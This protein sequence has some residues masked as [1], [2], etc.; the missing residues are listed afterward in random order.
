MWWH[1]WSSHPSST[2]IC[3]CGDSSLFTWFLEWPAYAIRHGLNP[4]YSTAMGYPHGINLLANTSMLAVGVPLAPI[5]WLFGPTATLNVALLL[6]PVLSGMA[7]YVLLRRWVSWQPAAFAGG[8]L[9]GFSPMIVTSLDYSHLNFSI[10]PIPPLVVI[11]LDELLIRQRRR[12]I[13]PGVVLGLL[14]VVQFF[15]STE[16]LVI[17]VICSVWG[18][19]LVVAYAAWRNPDAL[20]RH[21]RP[22]LVGVGAAVVTGVVLLAYPTWF[23][24][25][26]PAHL[27]GKIWPL[28]LGSYVSDPKDY[29]LPARAIPLGWQYGFNGV[30]LSG[31]Y[32]GLGVA[33]VIVVGLAV[34]W[35]DLRLWLFALVGVLSVALS[36]GAGNPLFSFLPLLENVLPNRFDAM[37]YLCAAVIVGLVV[38]HTYRAVNGWYAASQ[39]DDRSGAEPGERAPRWT[40]TLGA[41]TMAV[42]ALVPPALYLAQNYPVPVQSIAVPSWFRT[43][44][45]HLGHTP[46]LLI[47]PDDLI[48]Q[49]AMTW[50]AVNGMRYSMVDEGG[51]GG[52]QSRAGN[53]QAG[54]S[55]IGTVSNPSFATAS[56][57]LGITPDK[58]SAVR[59]ALRAWRVTTVVIPD[60]RELPLLETVPSVTTAA[61]LIT[62]ATGRRPTYQHG[63]WV[64]SGVNRVAPAVVTTT[65][66]FSA[67]TAANRRGRAAVDAA[68][69]C[70]SSTKPF[71]RIVP[72]LNGTH[73]LNDR[74]LMTTA[75]DTGPLTQVDFVISGGAIP[76]ALTIPAQQFKDGSVAGWLA[77]TEGLDLPT[78]TY[79]L[80]SI[81]TN[82]QGVVG[83]S[84][85]VAMQIDARAR[86][87]LRPTTSVLGP[88]RN[89]QVS[90]W[91]YLAASASA[92]LGIRSA[93]FRI[94]GHGRTAVVKAFAYPYG[95]LG[96]WNTKSVPNGTYTV[97]SVVV[98][99]TGL[100]TTSA[101]VV[102]TVKN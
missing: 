5:T 19:V 2:T 100:V 88:P 15:L 17:M 9:Y 99:N 87:A 61:A 57:T 68:T 66:K 65:A 7:M 85:A 97:H 49:S 33:A 75:A 53:E 37:L 82:A 23:A 81:T 12:P 91:Q 89:S 11:C 94:S 20:R 70:I 35:R 34:W 52:Y 18:V 40:G 95:F 67:C 86:S 98:A 63:A 42:I 26:G 43:V 90:G 55:V 101:G 31:Q 80:R 24:L 36:L 79:A 22:A 69:A 74:V 4:F 39:R 41:S 59:S 78:G 77:N 13:G 1:V 84:P 93:E 72:S 62:A 3:G 83:Q 96:D 10:T 6:G 73:L 50:Q 102:L 44:A 76:H 29:L 54:Q 21:A 8:L 48:G 16:I 92:T 32:F 28:D 58:I 56:D 14:V 25:D 27:S 47:L 64:W 71:L 30:I 51:P 38:D 45:P 46:V 60:Q